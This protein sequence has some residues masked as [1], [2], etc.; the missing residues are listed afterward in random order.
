MSKQSRIITVRQAPINTLLDLCNFLDTRRMVASSEVYGDSMR[1]APLWN[2][3]IIYKYGTEKQY[4]TEGILVISS[5]MIE[6][7]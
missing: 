5:L 7:V 2:N 1:D 6:S 3:L 4:I